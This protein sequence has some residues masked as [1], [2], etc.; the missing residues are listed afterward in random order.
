MPDFRQQLTDHLVRFMSAPFLFAGA[1]LSRRYLGLDDWTGLLRRLA[2]LTDHPFDY[3]FASASGELPKVA[4][5][6]AAELHEPWWKE[7]RFAHTRAKYEGRLHTPQSALKAE[8]SEYLEQSLG[9]LPETGPLAA[10]LDLLREVVVDGV[11][12]TN[13]DRLLEELFPGFRT[14]VGQEELLFEDM[15]GIGEIYKIHGS[16]E[17]P[18]TLVLTHEDYER[19]HRD[20]PYLA[21]KLMTVFVEH[22]VV[23]VGYRLSDPNV[24]T[25][26]NAIVSCLKTPERISKLS[27]RLIFVDWDPDAE[28]SSMHRISMPVGDNHVPLLALTVPDFVEVFS[29]LGSLKRSFPAKLLR[30]LKEQV[31]ELVL[32][33]DPKDKLYVQALD[34]DQDPR[35]VDVVF[36]V[37]AIGRLTAY[38][39][40]TRDDL[41][42]DVMDANG[43]YD[44]LR[45]VQEALPAILS[46]PGNVP[47]FKYLREAKL[48]DDQGKLINPDSVDPKLESRVE[49]RQTRLGVMPSQKK[50]VAKH[51]KTAPNLKELTDKLKDH[52][53][54]YCVPGL[55]EDDIDPAELKAFLDKHRFPDNDYHHSQWVKLVCLYDWLQYGMVPKPKPKRARRARSQPRRRRPSATK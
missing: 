12:T 47:V 30:K 17:D 49:Q 46:L 52:E 55:N 16:H 21:A 32:A 42:D 24:G 50:W 3:Y 9:N 36:G 7:R 10:E 51:L 23:F 45:V 39:G 54:L 28:E 48:L 18:D 37:G 33:K 5:A 25:I 14:F 26:L 15:L 38:A 22:P 19:F 43:K 34:E 41:V 35:E 20:N 44:A 40:L 13:F 8:A 29:V 31:Y 1:G 4:S 53:V 11:I 27:D 6:I 2:A